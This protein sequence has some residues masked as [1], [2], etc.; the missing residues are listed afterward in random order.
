[1]ILFWVLPLMSKICFKKGIESLWKQLSKK[2]WN[3]V[4]FTTPFWKFIAKTPNGRS[5]ITKDYEPLVKDVML[6]NYKKN[7]WEEKI[8]IN[9]WAHIWRWLIEFVS[10]YWYHWIAFEPSKETFKY[11]RLNTI[12]S[13]I[14]WETQLFNF[15]LSNV[16]WARNFKYIQEHDWHSHIIS[17]N[18]QS[19]DT[20]SIQTKVFDEL[21]LWINFDLVKLIMIDVEWHEYEVLQWMEKTLKRLHNI[22]IIVEVF[23][24]DPNKEFVLTFMKTLW[25]SYKKITHADYIFCK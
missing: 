23:D 14:E 15:W 10:V 25:F 20:I 22:D 5:V 13:D 6:E 2:R 8:F 3:D 1:M 16:S 18:E 11:L 24:N 7:I 12:L 9:I 4:L 19:D 21:D 17:E